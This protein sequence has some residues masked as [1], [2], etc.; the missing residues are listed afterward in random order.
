MTF[1]HRVCAGG[2]CF[3]DSA[4]SGCEDRH[5][6]STSTY[7]TL[8]LVSLR[9]RRR[10]GSLLPLS[11]GNQH[12]AS[13]SRARPCQLR[14][15]APD[16]LAIHTTPGIRA[17]RMTVNS[18]L[19]PAWDQSYRVPAAQGV[20]SGRSW[21]SARATSG[22]VQVMTALPR[23]RALFRRGV[24]F[25]AVHGGTYSAPSFRSGGSSTPR[26]TTTASTPRAWSTHPQGAE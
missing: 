8:D 10:V 20:I 23:H 22:I 15:R 26:L 17:I 6:A 12:R 11:A 4:R 2:I 1:R 9:A 7:L 25:G 13:A 19:A 24:R 14:R 21:W 5:D 18:T 16:P 3:P